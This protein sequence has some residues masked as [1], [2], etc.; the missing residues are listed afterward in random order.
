MVSVEQLVDLWK[1]SKCI[2]GGQQYKNAVPRRTNDKKKRLSQVL[3]NE[4]LMDGIKLVLETL[5]D[6]WTEL[7]H[8][9]PEDVESGD[10]PR[11][12][13]DLD[14]L[15]SIASL[16]PL[17]V[18][19]EISQQMS[20]VASKKR[21]RRFDDSEQKGKSKRKY[22]M[23]ELLNLPGF[24]E[25]P[26]HEQWQKTKETNEKN[27]TK[28][29][30]TSPDSDEQEPV[31][32]ESL[33]GLGSNLLRGGKEQERPAEEESRTGF[34]SIWKK[35]DGKPS[36]SDRSQW[37]PKT[38]RLAAEIGVI[39]EE[40]EPSQKD[41]KKAKQVSANGLKQF[42]RSTE[43]NE[44]GED[45]AL[46]EENTNQS[47]TAKNKKGGFLFKGFGVSANRTND[48]SDE[49]TNKE[50][51]ER[52]DKSDKASKHRGKEVTIKEEPDD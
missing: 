29:S 24:E 14:G 8:C 9:D 2:P 46:D 26:A 16:V 39:E 52:S 32:E 37:S 41:N 40:R 3:S 7:E 10:F 17:F 30:K 1:Q 11:T 13:I 47:S 43:A 51:S 19:P 35:D 5:L 42:G 28:N 38:K 45:H 15:T 18:P 36:S 48:Q 20:Q 21:K 6:A 33:K 50:A 12:L 25:R 31:K 22:T 23:E 27:P 34:G 44:S 4:H 49:N